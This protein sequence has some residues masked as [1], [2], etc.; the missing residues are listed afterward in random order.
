[1]MVEK[2]NFRK[3]KLDGLQSKI[4]RYDVADSKTPNLRLLVY[5]Q[6]GKSFVLYRKI[7]GK[8]RRIKIGRYNHLTIEQAR[9][10]ATTLNASIELGQD[11]HEE[12]Q[13]KKREL[14]FR[15]AWEYYFSEH[16]VK[17]T[18][19][20]ED[21]KALV[22]FHILPV[23]G[24]WKMSE[25]SRDKMQKLHTAIGECRG[26]PTANKVINRISTVYNFNIKNQKYTGSNPCLGVK[27]Y[28]CPSRDRF[29]YPNELKTFF[30]AIMKEEQTWRDYF[31]VLLYT[32]ARKTNVLSMEVNALDLN[33]KSWR[34]G[35]NQT[36]NDEVNI[37]VLPEPA[38]E[39]LRRRMEENNRAED[40]SP[41]I[42]P[43]K[44][45]NGHLCDPKRA[46]QRV[47]DY[48]GVQDIRMHDLRRTLG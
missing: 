5:P 17:H 29:L 16:A 45:K 40:P 31:L 15:E 10:K 35:E 46:W 32:G 36:K 42:F 41:Y 8:P 27:R 13:G 39:I 1:M 4:A 48:M 12:L 21:N 26:K 7:N 2:I 47:R 3:D 43:G 19:R 34:R 20:P 23:I 33:L 18:K 38:I 30:D 24:S 25:V 11:P 9:R 14:T 6:G 28:R 22:E 44:G 37:S